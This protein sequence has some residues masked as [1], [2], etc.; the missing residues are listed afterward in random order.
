MQQHLRHPRHSPSWR[1][2]P[3]RNSLSSHDRHGH[4]PICLMHRSCAVGSPAA[5][6]CS[7]PPPQPWVLRM[8]LPPV[9]LRCAA[10]SSGHL[11]SRRAPAAP[12]QRLLRPP[13]PCR[14]RPWPRHQSSCRH[15][16]HPRS[17]RRRGACPSRSAT[18]ATGRC[19]SAPGSWP[20]RRTRC[21]C[22]SSGACAGCHAT[23]H[24]LFTAAPPS[25]HM[26]HAAWHVS[27]CALCLHVSCD[28]GA[29]PP[30]CN[31]VAGHPC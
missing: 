22:A 2:V 18:A 30:S 27:C 16:Q 14:S 10:S 25:H 12:R 26:L 13:P 1:A 23:V 24:N 9:S 8:P 4:Q 5:P 21:R 19:G 20:R 11:H 7:R 3:V 6:G 31:A 15:L 17:S 29:S 28:P